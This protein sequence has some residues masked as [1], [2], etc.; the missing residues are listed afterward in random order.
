MQA[1]NSNSAVNSIRGNFRV[2][3]KLGSGATAE[4]FIAKTQ[5]NQSVALKVFK[6]TDSTSSI[7]NKEIIQRELK[8]AMEVSGEGASSEIAMRP[9]DY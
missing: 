9:I 5:Q 4:V 2:L 6:E 8:Y 3:K 7:R 1:A